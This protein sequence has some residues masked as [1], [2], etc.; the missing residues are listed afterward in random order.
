M[1]F[2]H[3]IDVIARRENE[4]DVPQSQRIGHRIQLLAVQINVQNRS[5][6]R[7]PAARMTIAAP[8]VGGASSFGDGA[9]DAGSYGM[10]HQGGWLCC[11]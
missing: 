11:R 3:G 9:G 8:S 2:G 4:T 5:V 6:D 10:S 1:A 7:A